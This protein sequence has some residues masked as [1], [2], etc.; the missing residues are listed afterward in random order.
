MC[1]NDEMGHIHSTMILSIKINEKS[2]WKNIWNPIYKD[3]YVLHN[4]GHNSQ[5]AL[6]KLIIYA[7]QDVF[8]INFFL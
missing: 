8:I 6:N 2:S 4:F 5:N 7:P 1:V 3:F